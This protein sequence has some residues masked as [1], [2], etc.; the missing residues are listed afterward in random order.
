MRRA[1]CK[2][3]VSV[4]GITVV[5][6]VAG[7][8]GNDAP[9]APGA[10]SA[11]SVAAPSPS[12]PPVDVD[13]AFAQFMKAVKPF[14]CSSAYTDIGEMAEAGD[15]G[16]MKVRVHEY[17]GVMMTWDDNLG[18]IAVPPAAQPIVGKLRELNAA[19]MADLDALAAAVEKNDKKQMNRLTEV[20]YLDDAIVS[21]EVDRLSAALGHPKPQA[22]I[23]FSQLEV[24]NH[25]FYNDIAPAYDMFEAALSRNDLNGAKAANAIEQDAAQRFIDR[26][27]AIDWP[28]QFEGQVNVLRDNLRKVIE[29][30][31]RQ[32][33]VATT[34]QIVP[35][36]EGA[37]LVPAVDDAV[38]SLQNGL[39]MLR[40][41]SSPEL[42]C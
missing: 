33:D 20:V 36:E 42:Q 38:G 39:S 4:V 40:A 16:T 25:T 34:A 28:A 37:S 10:P 17:R 29:F 41:E 21:V 18:R 8:G 3:W 30:D 22:G 32:V 35:P 13:A 11:S 2:I 27:D 1:F 23:A 9:G 19:E 31:R 15:V 7:C 5:T 12:S 6:S 14:W 26:L 24:T